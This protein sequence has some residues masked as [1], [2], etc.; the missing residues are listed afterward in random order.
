VSAPLTL[1]AAPFA[2]VSVNPRHIINP[3]TASLRGAVFF[4]ALISK[5][6]RQSV[7]EMSPQSRTQTGHE[8]AITKKAGGD[9]ESNACGKCREISPDQCQN[10]DH[11]ACVVK[12]SEHKGERKRAN[13]QALE[14]CGSFACI[15]ASD[16][17]DPRGRP[18][19]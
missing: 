7:E 10:A 3:A 17:S 13:Q 6:C 19:A 8:A 2:G 16:G 1:S 18:H 9:R 5:S 4:V 12:S 14:R 11:A 15:G